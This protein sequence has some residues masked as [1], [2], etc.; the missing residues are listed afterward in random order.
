MERNDE[1]VFRSHSPVAGFEPPE[2]IGET[3]DLAGTPTVHKALPHYDGPCLTRCTVPLSP[4]IETSVSMI[5]RSRSPRHR[6][7]PSISTSTHKPTV[8][9]RS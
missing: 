6:P 5:R 4:I 3:D 8:I 9:G 1:S 7:A 2:H